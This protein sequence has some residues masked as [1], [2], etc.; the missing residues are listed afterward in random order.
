MIQCN[1]IQNKSY[2]RNEGHETRIKPKSANSALDCSKRRIQFPHSSRT[3][4][5]RQ[6]HYQYRRIPVT[7]TSATH[8]TRCI[9]EIRINTDTYPATSAKP[10]LFSMLTKLT[11]STETT[12]KNATSITSFHNLSSIYSIVTMGHSSNTQK[13]A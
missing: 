7:N 9:R 4:I 3:N 13:P 11:D 12:S 8:Q 6:K 1:A 10:T 5:I 2:S